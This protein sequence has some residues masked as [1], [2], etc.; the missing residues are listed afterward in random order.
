[1]ACVD[2]LPRLLSL[3]L[4]KMTGYLRWVQ[5]TLEISHL[6]IGKSPTNRRL[7]VI[8]KQ[9][10]LSLNTLH[11]NTTKVSSALHLPFIPNT[12]AFSTSTV[13]FQITKTEGASSNKLALNTTNLTRVDLIVIASQ[14]NI[15]PARLIYL[16]LWLKR[17][18]LRQT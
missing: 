14:G 13:N 12:V 9:A 1:M 5:I 3:S 18:L 11:S 7:E 6:L 10:S 16:T 15:A 4:G 17:P 2:L 8:A